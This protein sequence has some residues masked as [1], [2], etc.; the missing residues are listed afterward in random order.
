[1][2]PCSPTLCAL[3]DLQAQKFSV[4]TSLERGFR[5]YITTAN[6]FNQLLMAELQKLMTDHLTYISI[7]RKRDDRCGLGLGL[8]MVAGL[9]RVRG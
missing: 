5:K 7:K 2:H 6:D 3:A 4:R 9:A 8:R 1:M